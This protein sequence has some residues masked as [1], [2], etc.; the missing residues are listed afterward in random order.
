M[1]KSFIKLYAIALGVV[2]ASVTTTQGATVVYTIPANTSWNSTNLISGSARITG[3]SIYTG[4]SGY[5]NLT[6]ALNDFPGINT[7]NGWY[8]LAQS[9][10][11]YMQISQYTTNITRILTNFGGWWTNADGST[12]SVVISNALWTY[13][14]YVAATSNAWRVIAN[15]TVASNSTTV[16][17]LPAGGI[18]V[19]YGLGFTNNVLPVV[20][21]V[22][23]TYNPSL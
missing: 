6:Y 15:G 18:P 23:I 1:N 7:A 2:L 22:T 3:I 5:S 17:T 11:G 20:S 13:T 12:N 19:I 14:N 9:N 8:A 10:A 16:L 21:T 4:A